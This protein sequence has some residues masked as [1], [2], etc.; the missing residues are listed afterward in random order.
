MKRII[1][2]FI[3]LIMCS[4]LLVPSAF[5]DVAEADSSVSAKETSIVEPLVEQT[6]WVWRINN[7]YYEKRLWSNT[8]GKWLTDWIVVCPVP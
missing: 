8:Y 1:T 3:T 5:A 7:G 2:L 6:A 4:T